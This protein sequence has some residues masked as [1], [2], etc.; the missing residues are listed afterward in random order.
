M[1]SQTN[2]TF[3]STEKELRSYWIGEVFIT[4]GKGWIAIFVDAQPGRQDACNFCLGDE[5]V[6]VLILKG[7]QPVPDDIPERQRQLLDSILEESNGDNSTQPATGKQ[8]IFRGRNA[9]ITGSR[10]KNSRL[11]AKRKRIPSR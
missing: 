9:G 6:I 7:K 1:K 10:E 8:R 3:D 4:D 5:A 11:S 2:N